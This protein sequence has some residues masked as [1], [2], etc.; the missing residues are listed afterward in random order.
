MPRTVTFQAAVVLMLWCVGRALTAEDVAFSLE[1]VRSN[2]PRF[3]NRSLID[4][5]GKIEAPNATTVKLTLKQPDA[6]VLNNL[7]GS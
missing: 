5:V 7:A 6:S 2:D 3:Q 1:R 4:S